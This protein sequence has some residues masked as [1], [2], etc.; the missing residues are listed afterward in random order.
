MRRKKSV[1]KYQLS[2]KIG[3]ERE[4]REREREGWGREGVGRER[5]ERTR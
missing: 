3:R 4:E 1:E 5:G 2:G